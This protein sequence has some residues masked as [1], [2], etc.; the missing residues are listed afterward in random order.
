MPNIK[1]NSERLNE[2]IKDFCVITNVSVEVLD[3]EFAKIA[4]YSEKKPDFCLEIQKNPGGHEKC[5]CS[6]LTLLKKC[7][8]SRSVE[9]HICHAGI[10]DAA[11]PIIKS[12][13]IIGYIVIGR[14]RVLDF[15]EVFD[16][17]DWMSTD[18]SKMQEYY[19]EIKEY[20]DR[21]IHSMFELAAMIVSF[22]LT[23]EIIN[24]EIDQFSQRAAEY[25]DSHLKETLSVA[26]LCRELNVS[27]NYL[28]EKFRTSFNSTVNN[29]II[30]HRMQRACNLL[31]NTDLPVSRIAEEIGIGTYTYFSRLFKAKY[32]I[33]PLAYRKI[34]KK[35]FKKGIDK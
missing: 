1:Y 31:K 29:Y 35:I 25:I 21:Q 5:M 12:D 30:S 15:D 26:V 10:L 2:V 13:S 11:M 9:W 8:E 4:S 7:R 33:S 19:M 28:Y 17:I 3:A 32:N 6:D 22:I 27:K 20:N 23:N 14:T 24:P 16:R 18:Y 34:N